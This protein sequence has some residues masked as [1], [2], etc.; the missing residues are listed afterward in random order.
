MSFTDLAHLDV[1]VRSLRERWPAVPTQEPERSRFDSTMGSTVG[2]L[3]RELRMVGAEDITL[4]MDIQ[5]SMIRNDGLPYANARPRRQALILTFRTKHGHRPAFPADKYDDWRDNLRAIALTL[6][7]LRAVER[8]GVI[9]SGGQYVGLALPGEG[10]STSTMSAFDAAAVLLREG[11]GGG[12]HE[13][14]DVVEDY[15]T[16]GRLFKAAVRRT[17]PDR[18]GH[19]SSRFHEVMEARKRLEAHFGAAL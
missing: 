3:A 11:N 13:A 5:P 12:I 17:H 2:L 4:E 10:Q 14:R 15:D 1:T 16:A 8:W 19:H 7:A 9:Q 18:L 6:E